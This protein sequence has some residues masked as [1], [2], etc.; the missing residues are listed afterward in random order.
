MLVEVDR[1][2]QCACVLSVLSHEFI[3]KI[4]SCLL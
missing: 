3:C 4:I 2:C 1:A